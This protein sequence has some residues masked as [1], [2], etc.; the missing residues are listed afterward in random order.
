MLV[1]QDWEDS[2]GMNED[3]ERGD[4]LLMRSLSQRGKPAHLRLFSL[5]DNGANRILQ[6]S[7]MTENN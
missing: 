4:G 5:S 2:A 7:N 1:L 6:V 3:Q